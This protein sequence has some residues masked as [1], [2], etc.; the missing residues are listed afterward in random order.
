MVLEQLEITTY[1]LLTVLAVCI[2]TLTLDT[3]SVE[4]KLY[5]ES[6]GQLC[7]LNSQPIHAQDATGS[8][9]KTLLL[10]PDMT[11][12]NSDHQS[13]TLGSFVTM[14]GTSLKRPSDEQALSNHLYPMFNA[15]SQM[16]LSTVAIGTSLEPALPVPSGRVECL[17]QATAAQ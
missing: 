5:D 15:S 4:R 9:S 12:S 16:N 10:L 6:R 11:I 8:N 7:L 17:I 14:D 2:L 1:F 3:S 13:P